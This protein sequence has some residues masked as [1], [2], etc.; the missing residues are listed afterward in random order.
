VGI[1][2]TTQ[3]PPDALVG[4]VGL[5]GKIPARGD[6]VR[7]RAGEAVALGFD[8]WLEDAVGAL[9]RAGVGLPE[10]PARFVFRPA[11]FERSLIGVLGPSAD[12]VGRAFPITLFG[13]VD[14]SASSAFPSLPLG[15]AAFLDS[16]E[17]L[18]AQTA[19]AG[20]A[21]LGEKVRALS[22]PDHRTIAKAPASCARILAGTN[23]AS[24]LARLFGDP[25]TGTALYALWTFANACEP[26][27]GRGIVRGGPMLDCPAPDDTALLLWL[28]LA[29]ALLDWPKHSPS[30]IWTAGPAGRLLLSLGPLPSTALLDLARP[31]RPN[32]RAWSLR[33]TVP[34][35]TESARQAAS[36]KLQRAAHNPAGT[37]TDLIAIVAGHKA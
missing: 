20:V 26:L 23:A 33:P 18:L 25:G 21:E 22:G 35:A 27:R 34:G 8:C 15:S 4:P 1:F 9:A 3:G 17:R 29:R 16:A 11:G 12:H 30:F 14:S 19:T 6:F 31:Q 10:L 28:E 5:Y 7:I 2:R 36:P 37:L 13:S 24:L 32:A